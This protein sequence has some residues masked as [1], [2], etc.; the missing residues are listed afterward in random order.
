M[1]NESSEDAFTRPMSGVAPGLVGVYG[2]LRIEVGGKPVG[3]LIVEGVHLQMIPDTE[4][5][6]DAT[7]IVSDDAAFRKLL[8][9]ELNP[10][11]ASMRGYAR[12][13][14]DRNFGT[15]VALGLQAGSPFANL[16][17][18]AEAGEGKGA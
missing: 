14:G 10:F 12:I 9:G 11:I 4:G 15:K 18:S 5:P 6:A 1:A 3:T 7:V 16:A 2:R 13:K 8:R 17:G